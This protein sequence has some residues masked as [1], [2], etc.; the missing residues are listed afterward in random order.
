MR[1]LQTIPSLLLALPLVAT[2]PALAST[3]AERTIV[4]V[5][6]GNTEIEIPAFA[7]KYNVSCSLCHAPAPR[8]NAF[9]EAF[10]AN[11][12]EFAP[13]EVPRDTVATG[14][15]LLRLME[16]LPLAM[17][18][19]L[20]AVAVA[21]AAPS[22]ATTDL[23]TPWA[24]KLLSGGQIADRLS[25]Y[26]YFFMSERGEVAG[27][28]DAYLQY[29]DIAGSGVSVLAGQFQV[30]DPL[31][32]RELRLE[33]EDYAAYRVRVG[34]ARADLTYDRGAMLL[35]SPWSDGDLALMVVNGRGLDESGPTRQYD[36]DDGKSL[37]ARYS[38][39]LGPLRVGG[40]GYWGRE[41][42]DGFDSDVVIWGPDLTWSPRMDLEFNVQYLRRTDD[43]PFYLP[44]G[45]DATVDAGFAELIWMPQGPTGRWAVS[46]LYNLVRADRPVFSVRLGEA[47]LLEEYES[48][49]GSVSWLYRRNVRV[50]G[51]VNWLMEPDRARFVVGAMTGF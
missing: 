43:N 7:R 22:E 14:D 47:A 49:T 41:S 9:G 6:H 21:D 10:A 44:A 27:L 26:L 11:G 25:Y 12:F 13:G 20:Y 45:A 19:D 51:E 40:F 35:W 15:P 3:S 48:L 34:D 24:I 17:R 38:Q 31:F 8:L 4:A 36:A 29:T 39:G 50:I 23:Q 37:A 16:H 28:E 5:G 46:G 1:W 42:A 30:S 2:A 32:K 33:Y 18:L